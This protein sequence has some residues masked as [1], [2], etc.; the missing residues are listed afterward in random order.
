MNGAQI[1]ELRESLE[2]SQ[3]MFGQRIGV[4]FITVHRWETQKSKPHRSFMKKM[5]R[6]QK[7]HDNEA[8]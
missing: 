5:E 3:E 8:V 6:I 2:L 1:R 4:S 7:G